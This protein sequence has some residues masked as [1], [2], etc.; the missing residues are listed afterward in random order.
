VKP[1]L[2]LSI[3]SALVSIVVWAGDCHGGGSAEI[4]ALTAW[5]LTGVLGFL[6]GLL[7]EGIWGAPLWNAPRVVQAFVSGFG[8][9]AVTL[10]G[11][12]V[13]G[14][15]CYQESDEKTDDTATPSLSVEDEVRKR[16]EASRE[17]ASVACRRT[18]ASASFCAVTFVGPGCQMWSVVEAD[19]DERLVF[20][21][22]A[23]VEGGSAARSETGVR[24]AG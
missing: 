19:R 7:R 10:V 15:P 18:S 21:L 8:A 12:A 13:V 24:C 11:L 4:V 23:V 2:L 22:G 20:P 5:G 9:L 17:I 1:L 14:A 6:S 16:A 3:A